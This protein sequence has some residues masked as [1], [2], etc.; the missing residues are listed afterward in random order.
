MTSTDTEKHFTTH[1]EQWLI[2]NIC[3]N[4]IDVLCILTMDVHFVELGTYNN[5]LHHSN[6]SQANMPR[7]H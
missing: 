2:C 1:S 3:Y 7:W 4:T 5:L 6:N